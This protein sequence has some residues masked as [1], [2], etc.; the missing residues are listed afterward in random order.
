MRNEIKTVV[1]WLVIIISGVLLWQGV[2]NAPPSDKT[3]EISYSEFLTQVEGGNVA[4]VTVKGTHVYGKYRDGRQFHVTAPASQE[5][6]IQSLREKKVEI[7]FQDTP[8]DSWQ[9]WLLNLAPL[10]LL[11]VL[12]LIMIRQMRRRQGAARPPGT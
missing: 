9:T 5:A 2:R 8:N 11:G 6:M 12:W 7:W 1:F 10:I 3:P 4:T